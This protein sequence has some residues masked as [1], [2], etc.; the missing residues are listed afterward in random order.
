MQITIKKHIYPRY[1]ILKHIHIFT[2]YQNILVG[3]YSLQIPH[4]RQKNVNIIFAF[5]NTLQ[6]M[7]ISHL[8]VYVHACTQ[9]KIR[10]EWKRESDTVEANSYCVSRSIFIR[11]GLNIRLENFLD[12]FCNSRF[13]SLLGGLAHPVMGFPD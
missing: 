4:R 1:G 5:L 10:A 7:N 8:S 6:Q 12:G 13:G 2:V 9:Y 3:V 11:V